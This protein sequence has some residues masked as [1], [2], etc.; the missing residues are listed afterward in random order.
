M[1]IRTSAAGPARAGLLSNLDALE[2]A[3]TR[4]RT[5]VEADTPPHHA[6]VFQL[7]FH[8]AAIGFHAGQLSSHAPR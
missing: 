7:G 2:A 8:A 1:Q 4:L 3:A 5:L 6:L